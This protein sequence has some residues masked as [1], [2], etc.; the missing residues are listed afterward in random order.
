VVPD[1]VNA[2]GGG[3]T[4]IIS[5]DD[6]QRWMRTWCAGRKER[7]GAIPA[8]F[9]HVLHAVAGTMDTG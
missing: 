7:R 3:D 6:Y 8:F 1:V 4:E 9:C 2:G 5:N